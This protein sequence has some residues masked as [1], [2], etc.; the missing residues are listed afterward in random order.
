MDNIDRYFN[1][2]T[3]FND[4]V[5]YNVMNNIPPSRELFVAEDY[6]NHKVDAVRH[7]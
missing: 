2:I 6:I 7:I 4:I 3:R 5:R 1:L